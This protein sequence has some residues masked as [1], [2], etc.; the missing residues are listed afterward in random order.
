M[1]CNL[2]QLP[3]ELLRMIIEEVRLDDV[4][5]Y[6][7]DIKPVS[8]NHSLIN[9]SGTCSYFRDLLAPDVFKSV[10]LVNHEKSGSSLDTVA[11]SQHNVHVKELHFIGSA[12]GDAHSEE[13]AFSDTEKIFPC[14]V[15][16][17]ISDL[18]RFPSLERLT[19]DFDY[20][21]ED[22]DGF[23]WPEYTFAEE[24]TPEQ[25]LEAEASVAWRALMSRTYSALSQ[26]RSPHFK[27][28]EIRN[29][30]WKDVSTYKDAAFHDFLSH[31][32]QFTFSIH[33]H[34]SLQG[35]ELDRSLIEKLD[36]YFFNHLA[37]VKTLSIKGKETE[38]TWLDAS[39]HTPL[40]LKVDQMPSLTTLHLDLIF[41]SPELSDFL[42]G[43]KDT[44]EELILRDCY[45]ST[46]PETDI[47]NGIYWSQL[48]TSLCSTCPAQ[49]QRLELVY[50]SV[51]SLSFEDILFTEEFKDMLPILLQDSK[52]ILFPYAIEPNG[53]DLPLQYCWEE[54][55]AA[56]LKGE[57]QKSWDRLAGLVQGN[58]KKAGKSES[59]GVKV[60]VSVL[61]IG[62]W[63]CTK[64]LEFFPA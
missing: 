51:D 19:L 39:I 49:L 53:P 50:T 58:V 37:S 46:G 8:I 23:S 26:N 55:F 1:H 13:A 56:F 2:L 3:A 22:T 20:E 9:W 27:H 6:P 54:C 38:Y 64:P 35:W 28:L 10:K 57:D 52:R 40:A 41:I 32:E 48:F 17:L 14:C 21:F 12:L 42:V 24:E 4:I 11:K 16:G 44:I 45:A 7:L 61:E 5:K 34:E 15:D 33:V 60:S 36:V 30:I 25:V 63:G 62:K 18:Q 31:I 29:L 59:K 47:D 43:H